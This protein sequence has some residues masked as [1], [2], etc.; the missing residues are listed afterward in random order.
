VKNGKKLIAGQSC[1]PVLH[2]ASEFV[3][4]LEASIRPWDDGHFDASRGTTPE[5]DLRYESGT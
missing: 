2:I 1:Q 3:C 4:F 5:D